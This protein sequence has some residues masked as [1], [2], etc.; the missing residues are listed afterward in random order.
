MRP[1][2]SCLARLRP[3]VAGAVLLLALPAA[4]GFAAGPAT[5]TDA[6]GRTVTVADAG[7]IVSIG[8]AV[9]EILYALGREADVVA[10]DT[11]S[12]YPPRALKEKPNVGYMRRLS[13]EGILAMRPSV[14]LASKGSGPAEA[15]A[16]LESAEVPFVQVPD[17]ASAEGIVKKIRLIAAAIGEP[18]RGDCLAG[19]VGD[20]FSALAAER[21]ATGKPARVLFV[22]SFAGGRT[23]VA[24]RDTAADGIIAL[25]GAENALADLTGYKPVGDEAIIAAKPD[26]ILTMERPGAVI[27][28]DDVFSRPAFGM[29]PAAANKRLIGMDGQYLLGFGPRTALAARDLAARLYGTPASDA[30]AARHDAAVKACVK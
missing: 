26:V 23:M 17:D 12:L 29:T 22:L 5:V 4:P 19:V 21:K 1:H 3:A 30:L 24:G 9:T 11:S 13:P 20:D 8:G 16:V 7:R 2:F 10:V 15:V 6:G 14:V 28:A 18:A 25:A 27:T